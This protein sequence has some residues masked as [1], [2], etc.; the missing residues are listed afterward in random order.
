M[1]VHSWVIRA[2]SSVLIRLWRNIA[3][4]KQVEYDS[5]YLSSGDDGPELVN[6]VVGKNEPIMSLHLGQTVSD[7][8]V[9][10][11]EGA[12]SCAIMPCRHLCL[13]ADCANIGLELCPICREEIADIAIVE[14]GDEDD[15]F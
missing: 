14:D 11:E 13:C 15:Y 3:A 6:I 10:L 2:Y 9:C 5:G 12:A 8:C 1:N 4:N 7:C